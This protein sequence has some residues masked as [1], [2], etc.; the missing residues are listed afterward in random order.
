V[1]KRNHGLVVIQFGTKKPEGEEEPEAPAAGDEAV[2]VEDVEDAEA[3]PALAA[4][5]VPKAL[6]A[7]EKKPEE[8]SRL[9]L[10]GFIRGEDVVNGK[11]A[12]L[13]VPA[14]KGRVVLFAFNP[15]HRYLTHSDFRLVWNVLLNWNDLP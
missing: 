8:D 5:A 1:D 9:V 12:I 7:E 10:S 15:L 6:P 14:G 3:D 11:P 4:P 2:E 13:D